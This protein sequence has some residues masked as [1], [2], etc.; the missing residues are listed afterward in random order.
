[1]QSRNWRR[2]SVAVH[3][4]SAPI[5]RT[6]SDLSLHPPMRRRSMIQTPGVA[7]RTRPGPVPSRS[8]RT[9]LRH[10]HP[11]TPS[12]SRQP[13]F[14]PNEHRFL[15]LPPLPTTLRVDGDLPRVHTPKD[16]DYGTTGAFKFGTLRITNGSPVSTPNT[17]AFS[18]SGPEKTKPH[19]TPADYFVSEP[20]REIDVKSGRDQVPG[21]P[22]AQPAAT[23]N[24]DIIPADLVGPMDE[25]ADK[26]TL[27]TLSIT[28]PDMGMGGQSTSKLQLSP[29]VVPEKAP[30]SPVLKV[31]SRQAAV[32]DDLF[33]DDSQAELS[34]IEVL[35]VRIDSNAKSL[36]PQPVEPTQ[37]V[38]QGV[39]RSDSGFVSNSK[40]DSSQSRNS[41]A[42]ADSGYSSNVSLHSVH[43]GRKSSK[44]D[45]EATRDS[46][47]SERELSK[48]RSR[49]SQKALEVQLAN[50]TVSG[51]D[52]CIVKTP[53]SDKAPTPPP[54]DDLFLKPLSLRDTGRDSERTAP[55]TAGTIHRRPLRQQP[56]SIST[57]QNE[58]NN[59]IKSPESVPVTPA[60]SRSEESSS[61]LS[62]GNSTQKPG[63]LQRLLSLRNSPFSKHPYTVHET[64]AVDGKVPSIP[65]DVEQKLREHTGLFPMTTKRLALRSQMSKETLKTILS[66]GSLELT[67]ED[68][69][70]P[71]PTFFDDSEDE[72][73]EVEAAIVGERSLKQTFKNA[74]ASMMPNR[75]PI[76]RKP[77]PTRRESQKQKPE[78]MV[79][80]DSMLPLEAELTSYCSVNSS[81]GSNAYDLAARAMK[82]SVPPG[83]S[84]SMTTGRDH[85]L[86]LRTYSLH[87]APSSIVSNSGMAS[88]TTSSH[89][90]Q[91]MVKRTSSPPV[92]MATR[93]SFRMPPPRSPLSPTGPAVL[94]KKSREQIPGPTASS[95]GAAPDRRMD[96]H[97]SLDSILQAR[98]TVGPQQQTTNLTP[99]RPSSANSRRS[100]ISSARSDFVRETRTLQSYNQNVTGPALKHQSSL[101]GF[102]RNQL[103]GVYVPRPAH[104]GPGFGAPSQF[105]TPSRH[106]NPQN[107]SRFVDDGLDPSHLASVPPYVRRVHHRRHLSA[108][109]RPYYQ[110]LGGGNAPYRILHSYNSPAYR[111]APIWG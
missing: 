52:D 28:V 47:E 56:P 36:P 40:S 2:A 24:P 72:E 41:L 33:E 98:S 106:W 15:S 79:N 102:G 55:A 25:A 16:T 29:I 14:E 6:N 84:L 71:T 57:S 105:D 58:D 110:Q 93:G 31:Q 13:S 107:S 87:S 70:P 80:D 12:L 38:S 109:S 51:G 32:D 78:H 108:G 20:L 85:Y 95:A 37:T 18:E 62:I 34:T 90:S 104:Q 75:K 82:P 45:N 50:P 44:T 77:V 30:A 63:R 65:R 89:E 76:V 73:M 23:Q 100:S 21:Q 53:Q 83:R 17:A 86:Q 19:N 42:K 91:R 61:S 22:F 26:S 101:D 81:L 46:T 66:V 27:P 10:S 1:M 68:E 99:P 11:P 97:A 3:P 92:S 64:H 88:S 43:K 7:T 74:A 9:S 60:S 35:D 67:K 94:R 39:K 5:S 4:E 111:N 59:G 103:R 49:A 69:L 8:T 96:H 48:A 54:K